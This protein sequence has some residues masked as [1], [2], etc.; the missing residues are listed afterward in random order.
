MSGNALV[1]YSYWRSSAAYRVRIGL[2]LK[3]LEY[4]IVPVHLVREGGEQHSAA[5]AQRNPQELIPVLA[6][7]DRVLT[8]SAAIL[9]YVDE[10]FPDTPSLLPAT[11]RERAF[12]R[13]LSQ[14]VACDIHPLGNLRVLQYLSNTLDV[15]EDQRNEWS[16]HWIGNGLDA[17]EVLLTQHGEGSDFCV[18]DRPGMAECFLIPQLY[19]AR[20]FGLDMARWPNI[21]RIDAACE[22][23]DAFKAAHPSVQV[24]AQPA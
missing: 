4:D 7:G 9:E 10:I 13:A 20:R 3:G 2:N 23:L 12:A 24:D 14:V 15:G 8:Q 16:K 22:G 18:G 6:H 1:L 11:A 17:F 21:S 5:H 19:N